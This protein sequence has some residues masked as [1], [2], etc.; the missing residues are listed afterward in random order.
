MEL[1]S[2]SL[3]IDF[4]RLSTRLDSEVLLTRG[5]DL[6]GNCNTRLENGYIWREIH[7]LDS[8]NYTWHIE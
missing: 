8:L 6:A 4:W 3:F 7:G 2:S 1:S 5:N